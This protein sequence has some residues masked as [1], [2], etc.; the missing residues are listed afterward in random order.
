[1]I[2]FDSFIY[3]FHPAPLSFLE[4]LLCSCPSRPVHPSRSRH[5]QRKPITRRTNE[6]RN[7][8]AAARCAHQNILGRLNT[9]PPTSTPNI[10]I[11]MQDI[12]LQDTTQ[13]MPSH[14]TAPLIDI[15]H[16]LLHFYS[17]D[18]YPTHP[19]TYPTPLIFQVDERTDD[20]LERRLRSLQ[21]FRF[22]SIEVHRSISNS[23][24]T[25]QITYPPLCLD[26]IESVACTAGRCNVLYS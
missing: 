4:P 7:A 14:H 5:A 16:Y 9:P 3:W 25:Y 2:H 6:G 20:P 22:D 26:L 19:Y 15:K 8:Y 11:A 1:M 21:T 18:A 17:D 24:D 13:R 10:D 12:D 23:Y